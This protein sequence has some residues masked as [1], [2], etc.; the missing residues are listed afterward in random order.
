MHVYPTACHNRTL[1]SKQ[2]TATREGVQTDS[3]ED[4][5][6]QPEAV[7]VAPGGAANSSPGEAPVSEAAQ[8]AAAAAAAADARRRAANAALARLTAS[9]QRPVPAAAAAA[10]A[11]EGGG[12]APMTVVP[13]EGA[14]EQGGASA[15]AEEEDDVEG[16]AEVAGEAGAGL[17]V[18][19][20]VRTL[21]QLADRDE[22]ELAREL[23]V[24]QDRQERRGDGDGAARAEGSEG[25]A[26]AP[27]EAERFSAE[28]VSEWVQSARG[29]ELDEIM[30]D[31]LGEDE[32]VIEVSADDPCEYFLWLRFFRSLAL[33][34]I[35]GSSFLHRVSLP[36][37][38]PSHH[39]VTKQV[40]FSPRVHSRR[41]LQR[42]GT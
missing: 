5:E 32:D 35:H 36:Q 19:A 4:E 2:K 21:G 7:A 13:S 22:E 12:A 41:N 8:A 17:L 39:E 28:Q 27:A 30:A 15:E 11:G 1:P 9:Q 20:G 24:L 42:L 10:A 25:A 6:D 38:I 26:G 29:D 31:I 34:P 37:D 14:A 18:A 3:S 23:A 16:L 33:M 40:M